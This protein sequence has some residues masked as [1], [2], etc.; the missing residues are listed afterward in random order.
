MGR[1]DF[2]FLQQLPQQSRCLFYLSRIADVNDKPFECHPN[3]IYSGICN[4]ESELQEPPP[5]LCSVNLL[6]P[7]G[8]TC[9]LLALVCW[10]L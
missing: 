9:C 6:T 10:V 8:L 3:L 5:N 2:V 1:C 7:D 4:A